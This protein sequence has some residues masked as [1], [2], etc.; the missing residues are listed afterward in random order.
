MSNRS[1]NRFTYLHIT[2]PY[3]TRDKALALIP[4]VRQP[5]I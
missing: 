5:I 4:V 1:S 3:F 2:L